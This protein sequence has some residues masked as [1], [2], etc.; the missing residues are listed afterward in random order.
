MERR[1][2]LRTMI[3]GVAAAAAVRTFPFRVFSFPSEIR[4]PAG[5]TVELISSG[6]KLGLRPPIMASDLEFVVQPLY[7]IYSVVVDP[8]LS[9]NALFGRM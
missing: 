4:I 3:G 5:T 7:D 2:F 6:F 8:T 1:A 9:A